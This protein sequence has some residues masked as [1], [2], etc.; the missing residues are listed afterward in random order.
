MKLDYHL[1]LIKGEDK[2][3][4]VTS[5]RFDGIRSLVWIRYRG[6]K[7]YPYRW[8]DVC[9]L[10]NPQIIQLNNDRIALKDGVPLTGATCLQIFDVYCRIL[11][12]NGHHVLAY[13][14]QLQV[15]ESAFC[16]P[17]AKK[18]FAYLKQLADRIG[19]LAEGHNILSSRYEKIDF[20]RA[21]SVLAA[22]LR[23]SYE[24]KSCKRPETIVYPFGFNLS[25]KKAVDN[26]L[27]NQISVIEGPPGTGKTQTIL[28]I[29]A[30]AV[31]N[32]E[33]VA[34]VSSNNAATENVFDKLKK[35]GVEFIAAQ[36]GNSEN[37]EA[38]I[39]S[40]T[41]AL[42]DMKDWG[43]GENELPTLR[44]EEI[45][46]DRMLGLQNERSRMMSEYDSLEKEYTH[47][48]DYYA[49]LTLTGSLPSFPGRITAAKV[50]DFIAE[51]DFI[52]SSKKK[53]GF[54]RRLILRLTYVLRDFRF[55]GRPVEE[56]I[57]YC[58]NIYYIRKLEELKKRLEECTQALAAFDF[59]AKMQHYSALSM[60][61][62]KRSL[63][64][65]YKGMEIRKHYQKEDLRMHS[66]EF[67]RDYPV[68]LSTTYSLSASLSHGFSYDYVI[69]D[70]ASQVDLVTG[71]LALSCAKKVVIVG[72]LK[73]LPNVVGRE[74]KRLTDA[75][76]ERSGLP[77]AYRYSN[78]SL[79]SSAEELFPDVPRVLL[80]EHYR[81]HPEIIGFCNQRFY[82]NELIVLTKPKRD[83]QPLMVYQ[84]VPGNHARDH[85]NQRQ[86]D[87]ITNEVFPEQG[88][89]AGDGS[90]GIVTP[91]RDQANLLQTV[92]AN[93]AVKAETADQFQ[94]QERSVMIF[95]TVDNEIG[96]FTSNPNRLNVAISRAID[97]F[98]VV[99][100][101]NRHDRTSPIYELIG[102]IR[103][104]NHEIINSK[105]HSVFDY[106]YRDYADARERVLRRYGRVSDVD[107]ENLMYSVIRDVLGED[108][109]SKYSVAMHV[110]LRMILCDLQKLNIRE[111]SFATNHLTHVDFL[112]F[113]RLT[114]QPVLVIEVDGFAYHSNE[115][116]K[117]RDQV[118]N[119]ILAKYDIPLLRLS[120]VGN[121][122]KQ[123]LISALEK[124]EGTESKIYR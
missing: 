72:D 58:Q 60:A 77:E 41:C 32:G 82:H 26:A 23:G 88:L 42:P 21:D 66:E 99:T 20:V 69:V 11:Y 106:L 50:L 4:A 91:Y 103:Y 89:N 31:M 79:L 75:I 33:S 48:G 78:H 100:D 64:G 55:L 104:H 120:T 36:L 111:L 57:P 65:K 2:T 86:I 109:F 101:G 25:Q 113:S 102:Y 5:C 35:Y 81:C 38:F 39:D 68:V 34:V 8:R 116:Q 87:V 76:F 10:E 97:Q 80:R 19:L 118:K 83:C 73:Q 112:I 90:V 56:I 7:E 27:S 61:A 15:V 124:L 49:S 1:V 22:F 12:K 122:E 47:F 44:Q 9:C 54:I 74:Q 114:H 70:E 84:T 95:S 92:F 98:I 28:N 107:S 121:G 3:E 71:A 24:N 96:D 123:K 62:F 52:I 53:V 13:T 51:Y 119:E 16:F 37:K 46:L 117:E 43:R 59:D 94:G 14:S 93:T 17:E 115:K 30:N 67:I 110:P 6:E 40:Q 63:A 18:C 29:I 108:R 85:I 45:K 105:I